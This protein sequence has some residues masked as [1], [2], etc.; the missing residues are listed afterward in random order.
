VDD[1]DEVHHSFI[2]RSDRLFT[3]GPCGDGL[4]NHFRSGK[5]F[6][7]SQARDALTSFGVEAEGEW[8]C[9]DAESWWCDCN[10]ICNTEERFRVTEAEGIEGVARH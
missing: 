10:T 7:A 4:A 8:R 6:V 1:A 9:H 2:R 3:I 5:A